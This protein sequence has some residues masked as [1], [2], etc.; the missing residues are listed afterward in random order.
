VSYDIDPTL[1]SS[2]VPQLILQPLLENSLRH[3]MKAGSRTMDLAIAA[4]RENGSLILQV[5]DTGCGLGE[6]D[7]LGVFGR[8]LG[9][10]NIRDRLAHLYGDRQQFSIANRPSGGAEVTLRVPL[11]NS[12]HISQASE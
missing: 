1:N 11:H 4:H 10:S 7:P 6:T 9:L 2:L 5:S 8:G 3:G 12:A